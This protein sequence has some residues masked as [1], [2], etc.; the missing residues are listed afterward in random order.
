MISWES[1][2]EVI[3]D[4]YEKVDMEVPKCNPST[5]AGFNGTILHSKQNTIR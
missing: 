2:K 4:V 5:G 3:E 1:Y